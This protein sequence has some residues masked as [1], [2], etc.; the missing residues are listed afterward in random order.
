[1]PTRVCLSDLVLVKIHSLLLQVV[2]LLQSIATNFKLI[3]D[4]GEDI[5]YL[6][7]A[8]NIAINEEVLN[9]ETLANLGVSRDELEKVKTAEVANIFNFGTQK[10]EGPY[11]SFTN[12]KG[13]KQYVHLGSYGMGVTRAMGV[14][15]EKM[16]D[17]HG[18]VRSLISRHIMSIWLLLAILKLKPRRYWQSWKRRVWKCST[19]TVAS[20]QVK[21]SQMPI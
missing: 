9:D 8:K 15:A 1:M 6:H 2:E 4:A 18:L 14:I 16:S 13:E 5:I 10:S 11:F 21:S 12:E 7:R 17:E 19:T 3:C 20:V